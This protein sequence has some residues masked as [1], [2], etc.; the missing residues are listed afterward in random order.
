MRGLLLMFL[1]EVC[2]YERLAG[3]V[4]LSKCVF[5]FVQR[6]SIA[7]RYWA[8]LFNILPPVL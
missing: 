2:S 1:L 6:A 8:A 5:R 7:V 3:Y 4:R